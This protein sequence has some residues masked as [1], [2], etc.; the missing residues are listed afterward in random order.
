[1]VL[2]TIRGERRKMGTRVSTHN[3]RRNRKGQVYN[4]S[5][6][7][8]TC[9]DQGRDGHI[10]Q[11]RTYQNLTWEWTEKGKKFK[12]SEM[13]WYATR[14]AKGCEARNE[15]YR[16]KGNLDKI[17]G[18]ED[19]RQNAK[20]CPQE[21]ILQIGDQRA[22]LEGKEML[23]DMEATRLY[24]MVLLD[25]WKSLKRFLNGYK[26]N[27]HVL[28]M[29]LHMDEA[30]PHI[31]FRAV[32]DAENE[33]GEVMPNQE[34]ALEAMGFD[35]PEKDKP[36]G[37]Y[38]NR[39]MAFDKAVREKWLEC[40][41]NSLKRQKERHTEQSPVIDKLLEIEKTPKEGRKAL[42]IEE[43]KLAKT[44]SLVAKNRR[45]IGYQDEF[46]E[47]VKAAE[48]EAERQRQFNRGKSR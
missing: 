20:T 42:E 45:I 28:D 29:A 16:K 34:K 6:N 43:Y 24:K 23:G 36:K 27:F 12:Q 22:S 25:A 13:E 5:H 31:H 48:E 30:T 14:Y 35:L 38:N 7:D 37:R 40:L 10:D 39:K 15:R 9:K 2:G 18:T 33:R 44:R 8:R 4:A 11:E 32:F 26:D 46:A 1:M 19:L 3:G 47:F 41:E 17:G 21:T